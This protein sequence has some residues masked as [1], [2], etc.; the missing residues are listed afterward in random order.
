MISDRVSALAL[1][2]V[3]NHV[4][5]QEI[6]TKPFEGCYIEKVCIPLEGMMICFAKPSVKVIRRM[7]PN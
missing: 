2:V 6:L 1:P 4:I 7:P 3:D 5:M